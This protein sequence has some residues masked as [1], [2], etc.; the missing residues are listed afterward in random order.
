[1]KIL[2]I[3]DIFG[4]AGRRALA[5]RLAALIEEKQIDL[6]IANAENAA[7]GRGLTHNLFKKLKKYGVQV[8]T[9]GN[10]SFTIPDH[11]YGFM[12]Y[13]EVLRPLNYPPDNLGHGFTLYTLPNGTTAGVL[14]LQ[15]RIFVN[16]ALDCPFRTGKSAI[17]ELRTMTPIIFVDFHGEATSEKIAFASYVDGLVSAVVGTHTHVQTADER[18]LPGGTAFISDVG[19]TGPE[20]SIIGMDKENVIKKFVLQTHVRFE[21]SELSPMLNAVVVD[22]NEQTG[23]AISITRI[24]ERLRFTNE[25]V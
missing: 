24:F 5:E 21:P 12:N 9:G 25:P 20:E 1:M 11:E 17:D 4:N 22:I 15:G 19:M 18:I 2:F 10:H 6:C 7:G 23:H 3:G 8:V 16:E 14:N 13:D